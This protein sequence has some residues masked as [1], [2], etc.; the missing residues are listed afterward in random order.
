MYDV[1]DL[2][3]EFPCVH[4][5]V[6]V[7]NFFPLRFPFCGLIHCCYL[8]IW[9][10]YLLS[11]S[12][13]VSVFY[14]LKPPLS[15]QRLTLSHQ[16][17][18]HGAFS[19]SLPWVLYDATANATICLW[20]ISVLC[21]VRCFFCWS[22]SVSSI[23]LHYV[24]FLYSSLKYKGKARHVCLILPHQYFCHGV[25]AL[26]FASYNI[27]TPKSCLKYCFPS[28]WYRRTIPLVAIST[29]EPF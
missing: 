8:F 16:Y 10:I 7:A 17:V 20:S 1:L 29:L 21:L 3:R 11:F 15:S 27:R 9:A 22:S 14:V 5:L 12:L 28:L 24:P 25:P 26:S 4:Y 19:F 13:T 6:I 18:C 23:F 2:F